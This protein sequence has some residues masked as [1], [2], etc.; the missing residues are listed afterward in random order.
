[1]SV[2]SQTT[3]SKC[4]AII[5]YL[6]IASFTYSIKRVF[7]CLPFTAPLTTPIYYKVNAVNEA[8]LSIQIFIQWHTFI[9]VFLMSEIRKMERL[10]THLLTVIS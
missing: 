2:S 8:N 9:K 1:M 5:T 6:P 3:V 7:S 10:V 4:F